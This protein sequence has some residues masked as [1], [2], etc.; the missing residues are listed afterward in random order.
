MTF[1]PSSAQPEQQFDPTTAV[2][3]EAPPVRAVLQT[4]VKQKPDE[5]ARAAA[6]GKQYGMPTDVVVRNLQNVELQAAV[7]A[8]DA[9]LQTSPKLAAAMRKR[10][11][12]APLAHDDIEPLAKIES[13]FAQ[14]AAASVGQAVLGIS[15]G[16]WRTPDAAQ[17]A[18]G[19]IAGQVERAGLPPMLN[20]IR[21]VQDVLRFISEGRVPAVG[22]MGGATQIADKVNDAQKI[23]TDTATFGSSFADVQTLAQNAD[24]ALATAVKTGNL[25]QA[26]QVLTDPNY[27]SAFMAQALPS[28]Y[29]AMKSGGS[30]A[31]MAWMEGM[32]QAGN[33]AEFEKKT[34]IKISD[35]EFTQAVTQTALVNALLEKYGL[36]KVLGAKGGGIK[37]IFKAI[38]AEGGT[39][40]LQQ[41]NSNLSALLSYNPEQSLSE[42]VMASVMGG[43][44]SGGGVSTAQAAAGRLQQIADKRKQAADAANT[45]SDHLAE[46][47]KAAGASA[48]RERSPEQFRA[49]MG[50]MTDGKVYVDGAVLNQLPPEVQASLPQA[51]QEQIAAA[52]AAGD[53]VE[54]PVADVLT[55][56][57]GTPLEEVL[58]EH[59]RTDPFAMSK[60][61][62]AEATKLAQSSVLGEAQRLIEQAQDAEQRQAEYDQIHA[63]YAGQLNEA[64]RFRPQVNDAKAHWLAS[65]YT[66]MAA[67][68]GMTALEFQAAHPVRVLGDSVS[69]GGVLNQRSARIYRTIDELVNAAESQSTWRD[70]YNRHEQTLVDLFGNDADLFQKLLSATSQATGVKGNVSLAL[71]AYD[72]LLSGE[73]FS[74][75]L[76]AVIKNLERIRNEQALEGAKIS[77]YGKANEGDAGAIAVDRHIAMLFFN[78]KTPSAAQIAAA[79]D[80]IRKIAARLGWE[81]RQVQAAL[82]AFNQVRLGTDPTKVE[83]YDKILEA[84]ADF[85]AALRAKHA[86]G[87]GGSVSPGGAVVPGAQEGAGA[88][89]AGGALAQGAGGELSPESR[90]L[91]GRLALVA[92]DT[93][94]RGRNDQVVP[95]QAQVDGAAIDPQNLADLGEGDAGAVQESTLGQRPALLAVMAEMRRAVLDDLKVLRAVVG[96]V[97]VDV[98][99]NLGLEQRTAEDLLRDHPMFQDGAALNA[100]LTVAETVDATDPGSLLLRE[101]AAEAAE[102]GGRALRSGR[103]PQELLPAVGAGQWDG[104][105]QSVPFN[106][107]PL[108]TF[109]PATLEIVLSPHSNL[110]SFFHE[111]GH[112]FLEVLADIASQP[113]APAQIVSDF[114]TFLKWA[115]VADAATWNAMTLDQKRPYHERWAESIEQYVMEGKAPSVE[116]QPLMR[117]FAAWLKSVYGSIQKFL[118]ARGVPAGDGPALNQS[119][120]EEAAQLEAEAR[121]LTAQ[122]RARSKADR[123]AGLDQISDATLAAN[124][125]DADR[126]HALMTRAAELRKPVPKVVGPRKAPAWFDAMSAAQRQTV[127]ALPEWAGE[128]GF[129]LRNGGE[130]A[131]DDIYTSADSNFTDYEVVPGVRSVPLKALGDLGGYSEPG[132]QRRINDLAARMREGREVTPIFVGVDATGD[133]YIIEGQHRARAFAALGMESIPAKAIVDFSD[134][135]YNQDPNAAPAGKPMQLNDDIRRVMD[136]LLATDEQIAQ[137]NE[138]AGLVPNEEA[139]AAAAERLAKRSIADLKWS[140]RARDQVIAKLQREARAIEKDIR[141]QVT[142]EVDQTPEM[143]AKAALDALRVDPEHE[144]LVKQH[145]DARKQAEATAR[146]EVKATLLAANPEAKGLVKGQ[147]LAKNKRDIDNKVDAAMIKWDQANPAPQRRFSPDD[148][149]AAAIA[150]SF[151]FES[152]DAMLAAIEAFG[153]RREAIDGLTEKRMLEEHGDLI[154]ERAISE[155]AN[156][157]VH[158]EARARSL[159][160]ELRTQREMLNPRQDT[161][162]TNAKGQKVTVNALVEA[163]KQFAANVVGRTPLRDLKA[164]AW[165]HTA[166]ERRA[167]KRWAEATAAGKTAEAVQAKQDQMLQNAAAKAA[168]DATAEARK[169]LDFFKRVTKGNDETVVEKGRDADVVNAARA[170][171][172]AYGVQSPTSKTAAEYLRAVEAY[173]P[174]MYAVLLPMVDG[175]TQNAQPLDALTVD[176]LRALHEE[177]QAMWFLAKRSRQMEV[178]GDLLDRDDLADELFARMEVVGIPDRVPG[179]GQAVTKA[180]ERALMLRQGIS[181]LR[182]VE[183][184]AEGMDGKYGGP[185]LKYIF[186]PI[187]AAADRYRTDRAAYRKKL[188]AL[189]DN[190]A[191][192]VGDQVIH[193]P[194]LDYTFGTPGSSRGTAMNEILHAILHT[195]NESNKRKL[196]LGRGWATEN[197]DGT[198]DTARWDAFITR[199][200]NEGKLQSAHY[201]FVQGVWDLL[202]ETKPLAQKAH[203]DALGRYFAEVTAD[204]FVDPWGQVRRGGYAP[205]IVDAEQVK[206]NELRK[207]AESENENMTFAFPA[208][209]KGFTKARVE[210]NRPLLL[211]LRSL[212]QH[213]DKVLLFSHMTVPAR[214]VRKLI[215]AKKVGQPLTRIDASVVSGMLQPWLQRSAQQ[216]VEDPIVG[217]GKWA[218]VPSVIRARAGAALMFANVSNAIQQVTGLLSANV[219]VGGGFMMRA[220]AQHVAHPKK[221]AEAVWAASPYMND[222]AKN[223]VAV[224]NEAMQDILVNPSVYERAQAWS[225]RNAYFLQTAIDNALSPIVWTGAYNQAMAQGMGHEEAVR[226]ADGTVRQTQGSTLPED[227]SRFETGPAYARAFTQFVGY[228]NMVANTNGTALKQ[229]ADEVGLKKG[230][231]RAMHVVMMGL[232][233]PIWAAELIA[234][235][236]K[237]GPDDEDKDGQ[238][239][240]DWIA[241]VFGFGTVKGLLAMI[242][243]AGQ[244]ANSAVT[245]LDNN[246]MNDRISLSPGLS[247]LESALGGN[248]QTVAEILDSDKDVN[249]RRAVRDAATLVSVFTGLPLYAVARP[250]G[251]LAG[252]AQGK[253]DPTGPVDATRGLI[254][255]TASP[256]SK[257]R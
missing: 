11:D 137:A 25:Q 214:D 123:D 195:G 70:W 95:L 155:A 53:V 59:A 197:P 63:M 73:Q 43:A 149:D 71:K 79:K 3:E 248:V 183:Q 18:V 94:A 102:I 29:A 229:I 109:N 115:G 69:Q 15:E 158:N 187:K 215:T 4:A 52:A 80:R 251:Y 168:I 64:A 12:I 35:A 234:L 62:A 45:N 117:R 255:G 58:V 186:Q 204:A 212:A 134:G 36:D 93:L 227:V 196:L 192:I 233:V 202:E 22:S 141:E 13:N 181:F 223:E 146:E 65:F 179:E 120:A 194:E 47:L 37:G 111:T 221:M 222:R 32:E 126:V 219:K 198:L 136:R 178:D 257:Q 191:P 171:L 163:A 203:R 76:P 107:G 165:Q 87:E 84:R 127:D 169:I 150:D 105:S 176:E 242:P 220:L 145:K 23:L 90:D 166:A 210:Y 55:V 160:S 231:G 5:V 68:T 9:R 216:V 129:A 6:L 100:E 164:R 99:D 252:V 157:A 174:D 147:L 46:Q 226:F 34:G 89:S 151:G 207:L 217:A 112:F 153:S 244:A 49:L 16:I 14:V 103:E 250:G 74:G 246:P 130:N 38:F 131:E 249:A 116:L 33:A 50:E 8:A 200:V 180:E 40:G 30:T 209:N 119:T 143:R 54:I 44:G 57:P 28:L 114:A 238:L 67:R 24:K 177:I 138:V 78:V 161:G 75:Y 199:L 110:S 133:A 159:A 121:R 88:G 2:P 97:P 20:P 132:E 188:Q 240:D 98:V 85:I 182:R 81:P 175:A 230:A 42:G 10:P 60:A 154:D 66:T 213:I 92:R 254:T 205:A 245:R 118:A 41:L 96:A 239:I 1:D 224:M 31:F 185:F 108:A 82:W 48:L 152:V 91:L 228:Y 128:G 21:G 51:V 56:A 241:A 201:D 211:D 190:I 7:D 156:E 61:D 77:Q 237:G 86:R 135:R 72:Q 101:V 256:E 162:Q 189:V 17:R 243:I 140:V 218:R 167:G 208:P 26:A 125:A 122:I 172:A 225:M 27:W 113:N 193:A 253:I 144:V 235:A 104:L 19:Y 139:D 232:L 206:D 148:A 247:L 170:V 83:S 39:E 184:W 142:V 106:R 124:T 236:F 173:D